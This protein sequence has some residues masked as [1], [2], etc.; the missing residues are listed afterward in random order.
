MGQIFVLHPG[1]RGVNWCDM[2]S[3]RFFVRDDKLKGESF[4]DYIKKF[5]DFP[6][7]AIVDKKLQL[8]E[9]FRILKR[10]E[11]ELAIFPNRPGWVALSGDLSS[12]LNH[13]FIGTT[14]S[15][16]DSE[17]DFEDK[18]LHYLLAV[19][20]TKG[21]IAVD[22]TVLSY[23]RNLP[24]LNR[25]DEMALIELTRACNL[26]CKHCFNSS[27][28][29]LPEELSFDEIC[30]LVNKII[31]SQDKRTKDKTIVISGGEPFLRHDIF[32]IIDYINKHGYCAEILTN[33]TLI[34]P[35][36]VQ[37]LSKTNVKVRISLDG[38]TSETHEWMRG[39]GTFSK[40][41]RG[42]EAIRDANINIGVT[43]S[44][45]HHNSHEI[46]EILKF[47]DNLKVDFFQFIIVNHLGRA[48]KSIV[49]NSNQATIYETFHQIAK[50]RPDFRES[51]RDSSFGNTMAC[52]TTGLFF[53]HCGLGLQKNYYVQ[54]NGDM[55]PCRATILPEFK[56]G[57][58]RE[59]ELTSFIDFKHKKLEELQQMKVDS[60]NP[61][62]SNC[63]FRYWCSG[64]CRGETYQST[65]NFFLPSPNCN[66]L[67]EGFETVLWLTVEDPEI[68]F[69]K[70]NAFYRRTER[71][72]FI[73]QALQEFS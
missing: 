14:F 64:D 67:I 59:S 72:D 10:N 68:Y 51:M 65:G 18:Q 49:T 57:N 7:S 34:T 70:S 1:N 45:S 60:L 9:P 53:H 73:T 25:S 48:I 24:E 71:V 15:E 35:Q 4:Q 56:L 5:L 32:Q 13:L 27:D 66:E 54:A 31:A 2:E 63:S 28:V 41:V 39:K 19:L 50:A 23:D 55:F 12:V 40:A 8:V 33:G 46:G 26:R 17:F 52:N 3:S 47:V 44:I 42:I 16:L 37:L 58:V 36:I 30:E 20:Y 22:D 29:A 69:E 21:V 38:C 43:T 61:I 62:C 11:S 6:L